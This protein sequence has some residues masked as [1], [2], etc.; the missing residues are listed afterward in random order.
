MGFVSIALACCCCD[1]VLPVR[2]GLL[3]AGILYGAW[4]IWLGVRESKATVLHINP[5]VTYQIWQA[6]TLGLSPVYIAIHYAGTDQVAF[7]PRF[8]SLTQ[9]AYGH[10]IMVVGAL[11]LYVGMKQFKPKERTSGSGASDVS[12]G[13]ELLT[14]FAV[15]AAIFVSSNRITATLGSVFASLSSLPLAALSL[16]AM[17]PPTRARR[18][19]SLY[20]ATLLSGTG[21]LLVQSG[22]GDSKMMLSFSFIPLGIAV[23]KLKK[24][25]L[26][27]LFGF[28]MIAVYAL[29]I[30]PVVGNIRLRTHRLEAG[31]Q[32]S[33]LTS[34]GL[35]DIQEQLRSDWQADPV[36]Y[37]ATWL[38]NMALRLG[39]PIAAGAVADYAESSGYLFGAGLDYIPS[40]FIPRVLWHDKPIIERG[41]YF[42]R[43]L[44][45]ASDESTATT[46]TGET[47]AG[48]L[49]WCFGWPGV[50]LGMYILGAVT[51]AVWWG[52]ASGTPT[53]G[54]F[55]MTVF[56]GVTL[57]FVA[58]TGAA[59]GPAFVGAFSAGIVM[60]ALIRSREWILPRNRRRSQ[61]R[62]I[63]SA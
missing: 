2:L 28:G 49:F 42:T 31:Q 38:D 15:G 37:A 20:W 60:R 3:V 44:G 6:A 41:R 48:E 52:A 5:L 51:S 32:V 7:G 13:W 35:R 34:N 45:M 58:G 43:V 33:V 16:F 50:I 29:I 10:A 47:S 9:V 62:L 36:E 1:I 8:V 18:S 22:L 11:C 24:T 25:Y 39:D 12:S 17:K 55:E 19:R 61:A 57:S 46:S 21:I 26:L 54:I 63:P 53:N 27:L 30:T 56:L 59:A 23:L 40:S 14:Y 4:S